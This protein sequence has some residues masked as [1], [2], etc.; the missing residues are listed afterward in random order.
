MV[1]DLRAIVLIAL[2]EYSTIR[3]LIDKNDGWAKTLQIIA[4]Q[5]FVF[6]VFNIP[7]QIWTGG[8]R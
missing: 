7:A 4:L 5:C 6:A 8:V 1:M 3:L 2:L